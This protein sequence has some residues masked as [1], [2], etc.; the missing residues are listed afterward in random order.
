MFL[1][2]ISQITTSLWLV[3]R[4]KAKRQEPDAWK[5]ILVVISFFFEP[6]YNSRWFMLHFLPLSLSPSSLV[7]FFSSYSSCFIQAYSIDW[8]ALSSIDLCSSGFITHST[9]FLSTEQPH[10]FLPPVG[11]NLVS[12]FLIDCRHKQHKRL[13]KPFHPSLLSLSAFA[14]DWITSRID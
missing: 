2:H 10:L 12:S 11:K 5:L 7:I 6:D 8:S 13:N 3:E 14:L 1:L 4:I 9:L